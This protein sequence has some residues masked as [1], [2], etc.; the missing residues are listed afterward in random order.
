MGASQWTD[1]NPGSVDAGILYTA[2][3]DLGSAAESVLEAKNSTTRIASALVNWTGDAAEGWGETKSTLVNDLEEHHQRLLDA[4]SAISSYRTTCLDISSK[5]SGYRTMLSNARRVLDR[6]TPRDFTGDYDAWQQE[7]STWRFEQQQ[8]QSDVNDALRMLAYFAGERS[9]AD[10]A[11]V[12][13]MQ[14]A[15]PA[16]WAATS[17]VLAASGISSPADLTRSKLINAMLELS[18]TGLIASDRDALMMLLNLYQNDEAVMSRYFREL[19]GEGTARLIDDIGDLL[20]GASAAGAVALLALASRLRAGL[21]RGSVN[22]TADEAKDFASGLVSD[23]T[24]ASTDVDGNA[25][26]AYLF[27]ASDTVPMGEA[28]SMQTAVAIDER[29]RVDGLFLNN[30]LVD[31]RPFGGGTALMFA[32]NPALAERM[33]GGPDNGY[34]RYIP[35]DDYGLFYVDGAGEV[36]QTLGLYPESAF[37]F[38]GR[39]DT[40]SDRITY[41]YG[42]QPGESSGVAHNWVADGFEGPAS[43]WLGATKV[44]GGPVAGA[45][46]PE[47]G[48]LEA[49]MTGWIITALAGEDGFGTGNPQ[50]LSENFTDTAAID[51]GAAVTLHLDGISQALQGSEDDLFSSNNGPRLDFT[52]AV[53]G[54]SQEI[55][56][57]SSDA[58]A[59]LLGQVGGTAAGGVTIKAGVELASQAILASV[60]ENPSLLPAALDRVVT[61]QGIADGAASGAELGLAERSDVELRATIDR[62]T[63]TVGGLV[64]FISPPGGWAVGGTAGL[65][66]DGL[67]SA[68][69]D[70]WYAD[71]QSYP[72]AASRAALLKELAEKSLPS[73]LATMIYE[74]SGEALGLAAP[75]PWQ[76]GSAAHDTWVS[77]TL[78]QLSTEHGARSGH[79]DDGYEQGFSFGTGEA[80]G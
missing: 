44:E 45:Y 33:P 58:F 22:W 36:F 42:G 32:E 38:I 55:A 31:A 54:E 71:A 56:N 37:D 12:S 20:P 34:E 8:A 28:L 19:G 49:N 6:E 30:L 39:D 70:N 59:N 77:N 78:D 72:D 1:E 65:I 79:I 26:I 67:I 63:G 75:P 74:Q 50:F 17:A 48:A 52:D 62:V 69:A 2:M 57:L 18:R 73:K 46:D 13:A 51:L 47:I 41:W 76:A 61:L 7:Y 64:G 80:G 11:L 66:E 9:D 43:L 14:N 35:S 15:L 27:S 40:A 24:L 29:E 10:R 60:D 23:A 68:W 21:S 3:T 4:R 25:A 16:N 5:A 53:T